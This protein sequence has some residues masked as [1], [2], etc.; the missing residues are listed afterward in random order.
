MTTIPEDISKK[1][2]YAKQEGDVYVMDTTFH[3]RVY[4]PNLV[5]AVKVYSDPECTQEIKT[6]IV[7]GTEEAPEYEKYELEY[8]KSVYIKDDSYGLPNKWTFKCAD[9]GVN[10]ELTSFDTPYQFTAKKFSDKPLLLSMTI[11]RTSASEGKG[12]YTP[13]ASP[14]TL[15]VPLA[16]T[17]VPSDDPITYNIRQIDQTHIA[18]DLD[19]SE[20]GYKEINP[21]SL[22]LTYSNSY[23][24]PSAVRGSVN[25]TA[26]EVNKASRYE[27]I[28]TL[29]EKIY[30]TDEL[31][32]TGTLTEALVGNQNLEIKAT[33]PNVATT[34][35][36]VP[37]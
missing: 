23:N 7:G 36:C 31:T 6:G 10:D 3:I 28:L 1:Y 20:F 14:K 35:W 30:N 13:K 5:P 9:T 29:V 19:N 26:A 15:V 25:I 34:F 4:D 16:I 37:G 22:K 24:R 11:E 12:K 17:V 18:I 21:S 33:A 2:C 27:L 32:L 8:G